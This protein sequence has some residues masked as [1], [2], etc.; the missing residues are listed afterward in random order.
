MNVAATI[1][2]RLEPTKERVE[3][4]ALGI[5]TIVFPH[6]T[7]FTLYICYE[8]IIKPIFGVIMSPHYFPISQAQD[9]LQ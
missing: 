9:D 6:S 7:R 8:F 5:T 3:R 4:T 1:M 2:H